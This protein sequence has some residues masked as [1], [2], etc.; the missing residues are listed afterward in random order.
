VGKHVFRN[1]IN[2]STRT[3]KSRAVRADNCVTSRTF[4]CPEIIFG[5]GYEGQILSLCSVT[6]EPF[7]GPCCHRRVSDR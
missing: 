3:D 2:S 4:K 7:D 5:T 6:S 1:S